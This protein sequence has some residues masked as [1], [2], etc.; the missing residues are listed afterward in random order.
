MTDYLIEGT[1]NSKFISAPEHEVIIE[2]EQDALDIIG[3]CVG[4][5]VSKLLMFSGNLTPDFFDLRTGIAGAVIQKFVQY[6]IQT[7][8]IIPPEKITGK[9]R[10]MALETNR[11]MH[12]GI[13]ENKDLALKWL[14][15]TK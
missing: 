14:N 7:A 11:G 10:E 6:R 13:F 2:N 12:F 1:G 5:F 15:A 3:I 4:N 9:F 8:I